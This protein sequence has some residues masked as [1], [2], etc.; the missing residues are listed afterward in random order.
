MAAHV[1]VEV[2]INLHASALLSTQP[3][4]PVLQLPVRISATVL[5][6]RTMKSHIH[7]RADALAAG[8]RPAHIVEAER[9]TVSIEQA[10]HSVRVPAWISKLK[11]VA[12]TR[13]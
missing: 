4:G 11:S 8:R 3:V 10:Q 7:E 6:R 1:I 9:H 12:E 5:A 13:R 2:P